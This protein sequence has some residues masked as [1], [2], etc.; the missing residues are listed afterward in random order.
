[1]KT[2]CKKVR[3]FA[4]TL[5]AA[6]WFGHTEIKEGRYLRKDMLA[7]YIYVHY[8]I[9]SKFTAR[10]YLHENH[11]LHLEF[12]EAVVFMLIVSL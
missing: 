9:E 12:T 4:A 2:F 10:D 7:V 3:F 6:Y 8:M 1:M 11:F 5:I